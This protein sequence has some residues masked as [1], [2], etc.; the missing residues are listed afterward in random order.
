MKKIGLTFSGGGV[1]IVNWAE[2]YRIV[3]E[4]N[5]E[6]EAVA[7][8][9]SGC[10]LAV[11]I[12]AGYSSKEIPE[13]LRKYYKIFNELWFAPKWH[14]AYGFCTNQNIGNVIEE[15]CAKKGIYQMKDFKMPIVLRAVDAE[16][17]EPVYFTNLDIP[18]ERTIK[19]ASPKEAVM[20]S[21]AVPGLYKGV[22]VKDD[23]GNVIL[24]SD[25]GSRGN[26]VVRPLKKVFRDMPVY[27]CVYKAKHKKKAK[28]FLSIVKTLWLDAMSYITTEELKDADRVFEMERQN[29]KVLDLKAKR[30]DAMK[31][32]GEKQIYDFFL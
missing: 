7:G 31:D 14:R 9:S 29:R 2:I 3:L 25:G 32:A 15:V 24:C 30:F 28:H 26:C 11:P 5:Y 23:N 8:N 4:K 20:A 13:L 18:G 10:F 19:N 12:A 1:H 27:A 16:N 22:E 21:C 17:G 6:L